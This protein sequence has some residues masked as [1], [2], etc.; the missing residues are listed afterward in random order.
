MNGIG[1]KV[2]VVDDDPAVLES[3]EALL[4]SVGFETEAYGSAQAFL[5][6]FDPDR[7]ACILLDVAMPRMDGLTLLETLGAARRGVPV[8]MVTAHGD[9]PMAVRAMQA[10]AADFVEKPFEPDR[11]LACI[12][13]AVARAAPEPAD[14][15]LRAVFGQLT[16]REAEVMRQMVIGH[17]NK[18]IAHHLGLSPRTVEIHRGRVMQKT[19]AGSLSHLVRMAIRAGYDPDAA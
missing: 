1:G 14:A 16:P 7:A 4:A 11:L 17:P 5:E 6:G 9:V 2:C 19:G 13:R 10:G 12:E 8:I 18:I 3:L 15:G